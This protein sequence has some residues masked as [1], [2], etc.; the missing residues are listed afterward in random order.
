VTA[1]AMTATVVHA[2]HLV[3]LANVAAM[4]RAMSAV[5]ARLSVSR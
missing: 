5:D 3:V 2:R 1:V 4:R